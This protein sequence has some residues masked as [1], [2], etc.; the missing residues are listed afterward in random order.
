MGRNRCELELEWLETRLDSNLGPFLAPLKSAAEHSLADSLRLS[1]PGLRWQ[2]VPLIADRLE[3]Q[4]FLV[5]S[6]HFSH[7]VG[8]FAYRGVGFNRCQDSRHQI[9]S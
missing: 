7:G 8:D 4:C 6:E 3:D 9:F 1:L 2:P 5:F